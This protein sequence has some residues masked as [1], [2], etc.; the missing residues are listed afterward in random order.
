MRRLATTSVTVLFLLASAACGSEDGDAAEDPT[1]EATSQGTPDPTSDP[2]SPP[3]GSSDDT[4]AADPGAAGE[5]PSY[6]EV[7]ALWLASTS[8]GDRT[9]CETGETEDKS[10]GSSAD[11]EYVRFVCAGIPRFDYVVG[12]DNYADNFAAATDDLVGRAVFHI[13]GEAYVKTTGSN[14]DLAPAIQAACGCGEVLGP[15]S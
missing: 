6:E 10:I 2:T 8:D 5:L 9:S 15:E 1:S 4:G 7:K 3:A 12:A 14:V 11:G 13:P